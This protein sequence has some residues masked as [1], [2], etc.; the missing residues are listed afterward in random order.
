MKTNKPAG[1]SA[2]DKKPQGQPPQLKP[3]QSAS[4]AEKSTSGVKSPAQNK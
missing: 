4:P 1:K 2:T 3:G